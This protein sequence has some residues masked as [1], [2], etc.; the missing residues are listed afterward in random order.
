MTSKLWPH[1]LFPAL[2]V[3]VAAGA[4]SSDLPAMED[5]A[6]LDAD[7]PAPP[8]VAPVDR[9]PPP[10]A[11]PP[12]DRAAPDAGTPDDGPPVDAA[13]A[14]DADAEC[15]AASRCDGGCVDL[16]ND[17]MNC[18]ACGT[19]CPGMMNAA[20]FCA[21]SRCVLQCDRGFRRF[22][23]GC[24]PANALPRPVLPL[25]LGDVNRLRPRLQWS[26][27]GF[28]DGAVIELC[29]DRACT[30]VIAT[31]R[32][33]GTTAVVEA[34]LPPRSAVY[35]RLRAVM[36]A[37]TDTLPGP[38]WLFHTPIREGS[39]P[40][41]SASPHLD[42]NGDGFD[43]LAIG[44]RDAAFGDTA[45]VGQVV[46]HLGTA[47]GVTASPQASI[48]GRGVGD[49]AGAS[50]A[51]AG[52]VNGDGFG[53]LIV[54]TPG[55]EGV[56]TPGGA[57]VFLGG[58]MGI[59]GMSG[60]RLEG[61]GV[62]SGVAVSS[63]GDFDGDGYA[64]VVVGSYGPP[65]DASRD[66]V[67]A[68]HVYYG[69]AVGVSTWPGRALA[70]PSEAYRV[71]G[72]YGATVTNVGDVNSDGRSDVIVGASSARS[73]A[74]ALLL[75]LGGAPTVMGGERPTAIPPSAPDTT[76][77]GTAPQELG[78]S[79]GGPGDLTG[80][81]YREFV[82]TGRTQLFVFVGTAAGF[83][84]RASQTL[85]VS[86]GAMSA[87]QAASRGDVNGDG[88]DDVVVGA[89]DNG[90]AGTV[91]VY[92]GGMEGLAMTPSRVL[93]GP[94]FDFGRA[95]S[96]AD[97]NG[98]GFDDVAAGVGAGNAVSVFLGSMSGTAATASQRLSN[99]GEMSFGHTLASA[100]PRPWWLARWRRV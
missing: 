77:D 51:S 18:G 55:P 71:N 65:T 88:F 4:C 39:G 57:L 87:P 30:M 93:T 48:R 60:V 35:W 66:S 12:P 31:Q 91:S 41:S 52:D 61:Y 97:F 95:V 100:F 56:A 64:D 98:D 47:T 69:S 28:A 38:T 89:P 42:V 29:R 53:D 15:S 37:T 9:T 3:V 54:G 10:D 58:P 94:R 21:A 75:F 24:V 25:S 74:G 11:A 99:P 2:T 22:G 19:A 5:D 78:L 84:T 85:L 59:D 76:I 50:V 72:S 44:A 1:R 20:P 34:P 7:R 17:P 6:A 62:R 16:A 26:L 40:E 45:S 68:A 43:D 83:G 79:L 70:A 49:G 82:A 90:A 92:L 67:G 13:P 33:T 8:D 14:D 86:E 96:A 32:A 23:D 63:A 80:D 36:G 81:G 27:P 73:R 46:V